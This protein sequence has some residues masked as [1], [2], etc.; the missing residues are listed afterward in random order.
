MFELDENIITQDKFMKMSCGAQMLYIFMKIEAAG[1]IQ[2]EFT[3]SCA[4]AYKIAPSSFDRYKKELIDN[5]F[6]EVYISGKSERQPNV[7]KFLEET[8]D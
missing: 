6:I 2:Y 5:G 3:Q 7:Y 1:K 4:K 8:N